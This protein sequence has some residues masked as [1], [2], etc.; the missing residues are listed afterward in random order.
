MN[1]MFF[2]V[3]MELLL[4]QVRKNLSLKR[5]IN[6][7]SKGKRK[8]IRSC[9]LR[10]IVRIQKIVVRMIQAAVKV[11][12]AVMHPAFL[13]IVVVRNMIYGIILILMFIIWI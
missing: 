9:K 2:L 1:N 4:R 12:I 7:Y 11:A 10:M 5:E 13:A 3:M 8:R 6:I